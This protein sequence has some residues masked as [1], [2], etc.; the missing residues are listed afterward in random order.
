M[1]VVVVLPLVPVMAAIGMRYGVPVREEHVDHRPG[2]VARLALRGRGVHAEAGRGVDLD[3]RAARLLVAAGDVRRDE[4]D[5]ADVEADRLDRPLGHDAVVV[6]DDVRLVDRGAA[7]REVA[8]RAQVEDLARRGGRT[9]GVEPR[10]LEQALGLVVEL[11][12]GQH[13]L[14]ADAA[15]GI[16]VD[17]L[18]QL[19]DR[20]LR[21]RRPR[22]PGTRWAAATTLPLTTR[23]R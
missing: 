23:M 4:V 20:V 6:V 11:Q 17:D 3:D 7:G 8:R 5:A 14:V 22:G 16:L 15:P 1:R 2:H 10:R 18:D 9:S 19:G 12:A 21:R 13:L